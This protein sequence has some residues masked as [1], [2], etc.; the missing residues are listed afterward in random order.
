MRDIYIYFFFS[1]IYWFSCVL[2][3]LRSHISHENARN[4]LSLSLV[5]NFSFCRPATREKAAK[6]VR[7]IART[8]YATSWRIPIK[9]NCAMRILGFSRAQNA[10]T[11]LKRSRSLL[12]LSLSR[13]RVRALFHFVQCPCAASAGRRGTIARKNRVSHCSSPLLPSPPS[14]YIYR[15]PFRLPRAATNLKL[16]AKLTKNAK[17]FLCSL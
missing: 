4:S 16:I 15:A 6:V 11:A 12:S 3:K 8:C 1:R 10:L 2:K 13:A 17:S 14:S 9:L 5:N 7:F